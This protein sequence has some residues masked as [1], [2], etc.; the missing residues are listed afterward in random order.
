MKQEFKVVKLKEEKIKKPD[1]TQIIYVHLQK[2][3]NLTKDFQIIDKLNR[4]FFIDLN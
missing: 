3:D 1:E 2:T 4:E